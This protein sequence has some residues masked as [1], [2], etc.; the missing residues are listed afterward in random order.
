MAYRWFTWSFLGALLLNTIGGWVRY[1]SGHNYSGALF[2]QYLAAA[3]QNVVL[4]VPVCKIFFSLKKV[5][6]NFAIVI[7][8][9]W[10]PVNERTWAVTIGTL[11]NLFGWGFGF[12]FPTLIVKDSPVIKFFLSALAKQKCIGTN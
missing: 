2:G 4:F 12:L 9:R 6:H 1:A 8:E 3:A 10:F 5:I 7:S 11:A